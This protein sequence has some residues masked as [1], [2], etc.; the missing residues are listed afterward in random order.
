MILVKT[1]FNN[2]MGAVACIIVQACVFGLRSTLASVYEL[3]WCFFRLRC[4]FQSYL[5]KYDDDYDSRF[6]YLFSRVIITKN[7]LVARFD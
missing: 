6:Y 1:V 4:T 7:S 5:F 3:L 2:S